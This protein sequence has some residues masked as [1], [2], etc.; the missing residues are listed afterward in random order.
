METECPNCNQSIKVEKT[1]SD[2]AVSTSSAKEAMLCKHCKTN[3]TSSEN[4]ASIPPQPNFEEMV[5]PGFENKKITLFNVTSIKEPEKY[6]GMSAVKLRLLS[7]FPLVGFI[8][9]FFLG[10][11]KM[12]LIRR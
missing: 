3:F 6:G 1:P 2:T 4:K 9:G 8:L 5:P 10:L 7:F 12:K 11:L